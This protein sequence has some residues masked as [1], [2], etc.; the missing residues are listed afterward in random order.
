MK[1]LNS[2]IEALI[3]AADQGISIPEIQ[4]CLKAAYDWEL[5]F[6]EIREVILQLIEKYNNEA[7][8]FGIHEIAE[9]FEFFTKKDY[10]ASI[11][12][13]LQIKEKKKLTNSALETLSIIA[14]KQ[15]VSKTEVE[16]IRGVNC[17]YSIQKLLEKELIVIKGKADG[18][19]RPLLYGTSE[20]FMDHFGLKSVK[21]LPRL[22]DL[23]L[24]ANEIG[25]PADQAEITVV[26]NE[27][28]AQNEIEVNKFS[29]E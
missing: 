11:S 27:D 29:A 22:K 4:T 21:D 3:F 25:T 16:Q 10:Y 15:P 8:A 6:E 14:Y 18:P 19:G 28:S 12:T 1:S 13:L 9:G 7:Y 24:E 23:H 5:K 17:D 20:V 26:E 2:H